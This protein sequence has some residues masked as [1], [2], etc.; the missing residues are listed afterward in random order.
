MFRVCLVFLFCVSSVC[1]FS[2]QQSASFSTSVSSD[3]PSFLTSPP[4]EASAPAETSLVLSA[5][6]IVY[7]RYASANNPLAFSLSPDAIYRFPVSIR[8]MVAERRCLVEHQVSPSCLS[9]NPSISL[10]R[11]ARILPDQS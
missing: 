5:Q 2:L 4:A 10:V 7:R 3:Q 9:T 8:R 6:K 11:I 1:Y